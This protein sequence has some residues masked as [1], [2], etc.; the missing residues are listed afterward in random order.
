MTHCS[1][2]GVASDELSCLRVDAE[3]SRTVNHPIAN[4]ALGHERAR[5]WSML[6]QHSNLWWRHNDKDFVWFFSKRIV[7]FISP[8]KSL[9]LLIDED[10]QFLRTNFNSRTMIW[11]GRGRRIKLHRISLGYTLYIRDINPIQKF[12]ISDQ[13]FHH[14]NPISRIT[15]WTPF[16]QH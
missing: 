4:D 13:A 11:I 1:V 16:S 5:S 15:K 14:N 9:F 10:N 7:K 8:P 3:T 2:T 12:R 6:A